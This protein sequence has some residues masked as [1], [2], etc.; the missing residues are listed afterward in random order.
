[1][2]LTPFQPGHTGLG[3]L[4]QGCASVNV[5]ND[6][7]VAAIVIDPLI[8]GTVRVHKTRRAMG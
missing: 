8:L 7:A 5:R 2:Y 3:V 1:M 6:R 4:G